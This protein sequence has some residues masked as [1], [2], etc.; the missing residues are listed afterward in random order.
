MVINS[1]EAI[2]NSRMCLCRGTFLT[3]VKTSGSQN[4]A[5]GA[6]RSLTHTLYFTLS[7]TAKPNTLHRTQFYYMFL[8]L[9][10]VIKIKQVKFRSL[11][12]WAKSSNYECDSLQ[13]LFFFNVLIGIIN[14]SLQS[15]KQ[16]MTLNE[17][18]FPSYYAKIQSPSDFTIQII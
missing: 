15:N 6:G 11:E 7:A 5:T 13:Y 12:V 14:T 18:K 1:Q 4:T 3:E 16:Y 2:C 8:S 10:N 9:F 17:K